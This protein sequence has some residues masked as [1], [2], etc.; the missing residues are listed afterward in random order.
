MKYEYV[1]CVYVENN[2]ITYVKKGLANNKSCL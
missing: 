1:A 2:I